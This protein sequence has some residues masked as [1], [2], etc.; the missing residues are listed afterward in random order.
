MLLVFI[1]AAG[2]RASRQGKAPPIL[3]GITPHG[4]FTSEKPYRYG[5]G[6]QAAARK[7]K[8]RG[9]R[10]AQR[11]VWTARDHGLDSECA[12][13]NRFPCIQGTSFSAATRNPPDAR[14][15]GKRNPLNVRESGDF[16]APGGA[17][18]CTQGVSPPP[19]KRNPLD[20]RESTGNHASGDGAVN[21]LHA[22]PPACGGTARK[23]CTERRGEASFPRNPLHARFA[24][25]GT[26]RMRE[27]RP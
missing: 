7:R 18:P 15:L 16:H 19:A 25:N 5:S 20:A 2:K 6:S 10:S 9:V 3:Y 26:L 13:Y 21:R 11:R 27:N 12:P 17:R 14:F 1:C 22:K 4:E 24:G 23:R 8:G